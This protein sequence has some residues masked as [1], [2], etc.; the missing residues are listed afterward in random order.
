MKELI[1]SRS[2]VVDL[3][4]YRVSY[5][6]ERSSDEMVPLIRIANR[7]TLLNGFVAIRDSICWD[8]EGNVQFS[9][10][11]GGRQGVSD[12]SYL[13][14]DRKFSLTD[15]REDLEFDFEAL[16]I[17]SDSIQKVSLEVGFQ[18]PGYTRRVLRDIVEG[19]IED[20]RRYPQREADAY[21]RERMVEIS[22]LACEE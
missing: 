21:L 6:G 8:L 19:S 16:T 13:G 22:G 14:S 3:E 5:K 17:Y 10:L 11:Y 20:W 18:I 2:L 7:I 12:R 9:L 15:L 4:D 1:I